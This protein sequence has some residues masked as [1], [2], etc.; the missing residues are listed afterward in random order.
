MSKEDKLEK[1]I[2]EFCELNGIDNIQEFKYS[3]LLNGFN[4][5]RYGMSPIDNINRE[6]TN[7][8]KQGSTE[9]KKGRKVVIKNN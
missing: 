4:I 6:K 5:E 9:K 2:N 8:A 3:C 7:I 1:D